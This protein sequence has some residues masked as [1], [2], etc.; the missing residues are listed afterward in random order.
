MK[1]SRVFFRGF[2]RW[3]GQSYRFSEGINLIE[4]PNESGKTTLLQGIVALLYGAKKEGVNKRQRTSWHSR[5][6]PWQGREY[7]GEVDFQISDR[8]YRLIRSL[9]WEDDREQLVDLKTGRDVSEEY[10]FDSRKDRQFMESLLGL[11][12]EMFRRIVFLTSESLAGEEQVVERIRRLIAQGEET[13]IMP[14]LNWLE[15]EIQR[16]GKTS[17][18]RT[19]P[20]GMAI[21][22]RNSLERDVR[23]IR[24]TLQELDRDKRRLGE[25]R[26]RLK[27]AEVE[28]DRANERLSNLQ[29][30]LEAV[31]RRIALKQRQNYLALQAESL[32]EKLDSLQE[33]EREEASLREKIKEEEPPHLI[34]REEWEELRKLAEERNEVRR[35]LAENAER[36]RKIKE[37][38]SSLEEEKGWLLELDVEE[39]QRQL[40][41][42]EEVLKKEEE[43]ARAAD[44]EAKME[45][46]ENQLRRL[47]KDCLALSDLQEREDVYRREKRRCEE[48]VSFLTRQVE[49]QER[50]KQRA[51]RQEMLREA[52]DALTPP[53][54]T[55]TP[56]KWMWIS[57]L[58]LTVVLI[59]LWPWGSAGSL[60]FSAFSAYR[61]MKQ[62]AMDR[63][64]VEHWEARRSRL[65]EEWN[66]LQEEAEA[67]GTEAEKWDT[68]QMLQD[69]RNHLDQLEHQL[70]GVIREQ[71]A[72]LHRWEA[73]SPLDLYRKRD[74]LQERKREI[75]WIRSVREENRNRLAEFRREA[76]TWN[77]SLLE[78]LGPFHPEEWHDSLAQVLREAWEVKERM[79]RLQMDLE[80]LRA[81]SSRWEAVRVE[82]VHL[83]QPW[84]E[85]LGTDQFSEWEEWF[86]RSEL[87]REL[88]GRLKEIE[89][90]VSRLK[91]LRESE[92]WDRQLEEYRQEQKELEEQLFREEEYSAFDDEELRKRL[93]K[94]EAELR[95]VEE[96]YQKQAEEVF[97]LSTQIHARMDRI[98][99]L[100]DVETLLKE[101][102]DRVVELEEE[103]TAL[104]IA[105]EELAQALRQVQEDITPR[106]TP[107]ASHWISKVTHGRYNNLLID[108][109]DGIRLSVFVPET[110]ERK[111]I[112]QLSQGT[113]D[114]MYFALRLALIRLFSEE[115]KIPLPIILDDSL[116]HFDEDRLREA[117]RILGELS[118]EHQILLCTCQTRERLLME[119]EGI[120]YHRVQLESSSQEAASGTV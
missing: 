29:E 84:F 6:Q 35:R 74:R 52:L 24:T 72:I 96:Q 53:V 33:L 3:V 56:W 25:L 94:A 99:P 19:K 86:L 101:A 65:E 117:L 10:P 90:K 57:G 32:Q 104:E 67:D 5:F 8:Q 46:D 63:E 111:E 77:N 80:A 103:R 95:R 23:E 40:Y 83:L 100:A 110:G 51:Q 22:R 97:R 119:E 120:D 108:P 42:L 115:G 21:S 118:G 11:S 49:I 82:T 88:E 43:I 13:E 31:Q 15:S 71:K 50:R 34:T 28:R 109:T 30:R 112:D 64:A 47:E 9:D 1:I 102:E 16:I 2:G 116:V 113:I 37:E 66:K 38:L 92:D 20:Y 61:W 91:Q 14:A 98:P 4:A 69:A 68:K 89:E 76:E 41:R 39:L 85:Q 70:D 17:Q 81:D 54:P 73:D 78:Q 59:V 62:R 55:D 44:G 60:L 58:A 12:R 106:L 114:Q 105:K 75:E 107:H 7:G 48:E 93:M 87:V 36:Y 18:A 27:I 26:E 45:E 79:R